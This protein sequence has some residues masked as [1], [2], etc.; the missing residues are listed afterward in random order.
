LDGPRDHASHADDE[1]YAELAH[2]VMHRQA[3]LSRRVAAVFLII[4]FGLPL[5][6]HFYPLAANRPAF[7]FTATWLFL[8][9]LFYPI[10]WFL[11]WYFI[12]ESDKIEAESHTWDHLLPGRS[13]E[14]RE[15]H[16]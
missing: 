6:N 16:A 15:D 4:L 10:T 9:V 12:R 13:A 11:S 5:F 2:A 14:S 1:Q 7:G 8:G 3:A